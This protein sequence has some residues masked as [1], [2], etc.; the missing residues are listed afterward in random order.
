MINIECYRRG[1]GGAKLVSYSVSDY[2]DDV[3]NTSRVLFFLS[4]NLISWHSLK[5]RVVVMSLCEAEYVA[6]TS[7]A[8]QGIW[9]AWLLADLRQEET[10]P[11]EL[12]VDNKSA[13]ALM[14]N[15]VFHEH[16]KHIRV[17]YHYVRECVEEGSILAD[18]I[19][20]QDQFTDIGTKALGRVGFQELCSKIGMVQINS[21]LK[22]KT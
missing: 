10:E 12:R 14:K 8:T 2:A 16:R 3:D 4:K 17:R 1:K 6:A 9:L 19:S 15:L 7:A 20:T 21:R 22:H 13:L 5:Q 11:V 18:F